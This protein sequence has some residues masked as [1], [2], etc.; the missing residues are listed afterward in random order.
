MAEASS[1]PTPLVG[2][3]AVSF[4]TRRGRYEDVSAMPWWLVVRGYAKWTICFLG[5]TA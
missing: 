5:L 4:P 3:L 1:G 2:K